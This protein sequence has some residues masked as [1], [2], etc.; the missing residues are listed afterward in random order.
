[1]SIE[2]SPPSVTASPV[3]SIQ[4]MSFRPQKR[5]L[6][7]HL[8]QTVHT[9]ENDEG[10]YAEAEAKGSVEDDRD[11]LGPEEEQIG[12]E[13]VAAMITGHQGGEQAIEKEWEKDPVGEDI[14]RR[15]EPVPRG[16]SSLEPPEP[17]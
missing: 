9:E 10:L 15:D 2:S 17:P 1:M 3:P 8:R 7:F 5:N 16:E 6:V 13:E 4:G 11:H 12:G 14:G